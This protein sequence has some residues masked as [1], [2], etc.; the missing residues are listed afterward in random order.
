ML[1]GGGVAALHRTRGVAEILRE[2]FEALSRD[3]GGFLE[4]LRHF[5]QLRVGR[6]VEVLVDVA[7]FVCGFVQVEFE[8][9]RC[10]RLC[11]A[12]RIER[13]CDALESIRYS[14]GVEAAFGKTLLKFGQALAE[15]VL[16]HA[17][18]LKGTDNLSELLGQVGL[19]QLLRPA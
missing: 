3:V 19:L 4:T 12:G 13:L 9:L 15:L 5:A 14:S 8:D 17:A 11:E 10:D 18:V 2:L 16:G 6:R 1:S 7:N